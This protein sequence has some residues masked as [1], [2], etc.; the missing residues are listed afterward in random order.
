MRVMTQFIQD[1]TDGS[2]DGEID[3][4]VGRR[5]AG[6]LRSRG[7]SR[8]EAAAT[9]DLTHR[10]FCR[11]L[12]G[13]RSFRVGELVALANFAGFDVA[14]VLE[15]GRLPTAGPGS[16]TPTALFDTKEAARRLG[17]TVTWLRDHRRDVPH[18][19]VGRLVRYTQAHLDR[20]IELNTHDPNLL[21]RSA[22]SRRL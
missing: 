15:P 16:D 7:L 22:R 21:R 20:Y 9:A 3:R 4:H 10:A 1:R 18:V 14:E 8:H 12:A 6:I 11:T 2:P 13:E 17:V 5:L 19:K